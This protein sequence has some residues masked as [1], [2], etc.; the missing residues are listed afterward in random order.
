MQFLGLL[1]TGVVIYLA[2]RR[3]PPVRMYGLILQFLGP[4]IRG[5]LLCTCKI[6]GSYLNAAAQ[7]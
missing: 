5:E 2:D 3:Y 6:G 4:L 7:V 1:I